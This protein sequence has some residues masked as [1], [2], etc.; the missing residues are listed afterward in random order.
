MSKPIVSGQGE[1][2]GIS[3]AE[4]IIVLSPVCVVAGILWMVFAMDRGRFAWSGDIVTLL[5]LVATLVGAFGGIGLAINRNNGWWFLVTLA[6]AGLG[7]LE[8]QLFFAIGMSRM[9]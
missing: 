3:Y 5:M 1:F 4:Y 8:L 7:F 2:K 6:C 9:H